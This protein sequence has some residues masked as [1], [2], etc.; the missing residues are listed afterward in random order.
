MSRSV[1]L[2]RQF[3]PHHTICSA[4]YTQ[5]CSQCYKCVNGE[6]SGIKGVPVLAISGSWISSGT[7]FQ[8]VTAFQNASIY[9]RKYQPS[10]PVTRVKNLI[11]STD[12][13]PGEASAETRGARRINDCRSTL[14]WCR[15]RARQRAALL[16]L[17]AFRLAQQFFV[18]RG[19]TAFGTDVRRV[20][21]V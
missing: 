14:V 5:E 13:K 2:W 3:A 17:Q 18:I 9:C 19:S 1:R 6:T 10:K 21:N 15:N 11:K 20:A 4:C 8:L 16:I 7:S 12:F